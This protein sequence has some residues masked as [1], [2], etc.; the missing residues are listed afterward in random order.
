MFDPRTRPADSRLGRGTDPV[1]QEAGLVRR[2]A[3]TMRRILLVLVVVGVVL[4]ATPAQAATI[5]ERA[6]VRMRDGVLL[7]VDIWRPSDIAQVPVILRMTP[8]HMLDKALAPRDPG[9]P[10][11]WG[12]EFVGR[13]YAFV[14][15]DIRGT[16][17]S[18]G[19]WDYGGVKERED[20]YDLVEWLGTRD[21]SNGKV[22]MIGGSYDGTAANA[23]AVEQPPHLATIVPISSISRWYG[24][25]YQQGTRATISGESDD[26][27][28]PGVTPPDFMFGYGAAP[29]LDPNAD[30]GASLADR[31]TP[32]DR[33][34]QTLHAYDTQPDYDAFWDE[35]DYLA[36]AQ[37]VQVPVLVTH[38]FTDFNVKTWEGTAWFQALPGEK[39]AVFGQW[40]HALPEAYPAWRT[41]LRKWFDRW[42][43]GVQNGVENEAAVRVQSSDGAWRTQE[44]W[45]EGASTAYALQG[46]PV[47]IMDD[48]LLTESEM[49]RGMSSGRYAR[50]V[51]PGTTGGLWIEGR[52]VLRLSASS[53][54]PG[55]H[56]VAV[57]CDVGPSGECGVISRAFLNAR[58]ADGLQT[59]RDLAPGQQRTFDLEFIDKDYKLPADHHLAVIV[60]SSSTT[61]VAPDEHRATNTL[62]PAASW[63][64]LPLR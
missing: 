52:P 50:W 51:V 22:G 55:T 54:S 8:Y 37:Q 60:A 62:Y 4:P 9:P 38:G 44:T 46:D 34:E 12:I 56:F 35:R 36:R 41:L 7:S 26:I 27:D 33:A 45:G 17:A 14:V 19:C 23:A 53:D 57:L 32:C 42:L 10:A 1:R 25:A 11:Q 15:A 3:S 20:G 64:D 59:G 39:T 48:G 24:Y 61:W 6:A 43:K 63:L 30:V 58:Y 5:H 13:G 21:W 28:P 49:L 40:G 29:P 31:W 18:G 2:T 47:T 16:Y